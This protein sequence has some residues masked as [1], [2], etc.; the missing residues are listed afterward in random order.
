MHLKPEELVDLAEGTITESSVPHLAACAACRGQL[1]AL[2]VMTT[3]ACDFEVPEPSPLFWDHLS[4]RVQDA[5]AADHQQS[6]AWL[7]WLGLGTS[8]TGQGVGSWKDLWEP[9]SLGIVVAA[10]IAVL[11]ALGTLTPWAHRIPGM[12]TMR[13]DGAS[14]VAPDQDTIDS[15]AGMAARIGLSGALGNFGSAGSPGNN[16]AVES[17]LGLVTDLTAGLDWDTANE[18]GLASDNSAEHEVTHMTNDELRELQRLLKE[19]LARSGA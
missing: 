4:S 5:I 17:S 11:V 19:E 18:A 3:E 8:P 9:R 13:S 14:S 15:V 16:D 2:R 7:R 12:G 6:S 10:G 1:E